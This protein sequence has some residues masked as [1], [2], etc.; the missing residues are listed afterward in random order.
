MPVSNSFTWSLTDSK[1]F[2]T[3]IAFFSTSLSI[4]FTFSAN[5]SVTFWASFAA[6]SVAFLASSAAFSD[7]PPIAAAASLA[8]SA[9]LRATA[10]ASFAA[11]SA[12]SLL[13][14]IS[15]SA[16]SRASNSV[17]SCS[18]TEKM[19]SRVWASSGSRSPSASILSRFL[20]ASSTSSDSSL[21][22]APIS[23]NEGGSKGNM[24][25]F[26]SFCFFGSSASFSF[27]RDSL[28]FSAAIR[29]S[30]RAILARY[31]AIK[32]S[33]VLGPRFFSLSSP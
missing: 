24:P 14:R 17:E 6:A 15:S 3:E 18:S 9:A 33:I 4:T 1:S 27:F 10:S 7:P 31:S 23:A 8:A 26:A 29:R 32:S 28:A 5:S 20:R 13:F 12:A 2:P 21:T 30:R 16:V 22:L 11:F 25:C 19:P